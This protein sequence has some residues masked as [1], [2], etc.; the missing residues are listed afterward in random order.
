MKNIFYSFFYKQKKINHLAIFNGLTAPPAKLCVRKLIVVIYCLAVVIPCLL[1]GMAI[2]GEGSEFFN[3]RSM[4]RDSGVKIFPDLV[5]IGHAGEMQPGLGWSI[6]GTQLGGGDIELLPS[7]KVNSVF[8]RSGNGISGRFS[9]DYTSDQNHQKATGNSNK[10][11]GGFLTEVEEKEFEEIK[12]SAKRHIIASLIG[13]LMGCLFI[14]FTQRKAHR[15]ARMRAD[16][17]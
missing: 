17:V 2:A 3:C 9:A 6:S 15:E 1:V 4:N 13:G 14:I 5:F 11:I 7:Q 10:R 8:V 12:D 16:P